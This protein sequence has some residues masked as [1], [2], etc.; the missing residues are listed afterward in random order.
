[1]AAT[2]AQSFSEVHELPARDLMPVVD[3][4]PADETCTVYVMTRDKCWKATRARQ[5]WPVV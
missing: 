2:S 5:A 3:G 1:V 4:A